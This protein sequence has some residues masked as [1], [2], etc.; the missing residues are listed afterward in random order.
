MTNLSVFEH[1]GDLVVD[2]RLIAQE[3]GIEHKNLLATIDKHLN[4]IQKFGTVAFE[5][6]EFK[7]SRGNRSTERFAYLTEDQASFVMTLSRNTE[8]VLECKFNLVKAF[9]DARSIIKQV[10][11][12]QQEEIEKLR[13]QLELAKTQERLFSTTQAIA[14]MHGTEMVA[15]ILGKPDAVVVQTEV[16]KQTVIVDQRGRAV[17]ENDGVGIGY[18]TKALGFKTNNQT[19]AWLESIGYGKN[20]GKWVEELTAH[21]NLKLPRDVFRELKRAWSQRKGN[22]QR[23]IGES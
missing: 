18:L 14:T 10:I 22:R 23:L 21:T 16:V 12:A 17:Q 6:R 15:L 7:T 4:R 9:S 3:L 13:L 2:S 1:R 5:T 11:P 19:W 8:Q 20:S